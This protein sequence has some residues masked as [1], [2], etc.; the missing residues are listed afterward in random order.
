MFSVNLNRA[1]SRG[2]NKLFKK[3][4]GKMHRFY[5]AAGYLSR[6]IY[7][8]LKSLPQDFAGEVCEIRLRSGNF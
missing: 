5:K 2:S 6:R 8:A 1:C 4:G 7:A 3:G